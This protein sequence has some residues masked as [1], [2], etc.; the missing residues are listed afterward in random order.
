MYAIRS[1][2]DFAERLAA[3]QSQLETN[4]DIWVFQHLYQ[5]KNVPVMYTTAA[6]GKMTSGNHELKVEFSYNFV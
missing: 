6:I 3:D 2:Y 1:Y 5:E 4:Q